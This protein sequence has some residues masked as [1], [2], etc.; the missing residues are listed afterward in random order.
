MAVLPGLNSCM[1]WANGRGILLVNESFN[2]TTGTL[3]PNSFYEFYVRDFNRCLLRVLP[4]QLPQLSLLDDYVFTQMV[5]NDTTGNSVMILG[6][7][8]VGMPTQ[9]HGVSAVV[10]L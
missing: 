1:V 9:L 4:L 5:V 7:Y 8:K 6:G 10:C 2:P 3:I